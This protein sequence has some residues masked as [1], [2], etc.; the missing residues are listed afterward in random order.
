MYGCIQILERLRKAEAEAAELRA[1]L[2]Q[3]PPADEMSDVKARLSKE[4]GEQGKGSAEIT[5]ANPL[6]RGGRQGNNMVGPSEAG[7]IDELGIKETENVGEVIRKRFTL[8]LGGSAV[9]ALLAFVPTQ[10]HQLPKE[11]ANVYIAPVIRSKILLDDIQDTIERGRWKQMLQL[12]RQILDRPNYLKKNVALAAQALPSDEDWKRADG[13]GRELVEN[14][15]ALDYQEFFQTEEPNAD[16]AA[17]LEQGVQQCLDKIEDF[18]NMMPR[19][20]YVKADEEAQRTR[21]AVARDTLTYT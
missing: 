18:L 21:S 10:T 11:P 2:A 7:L 12:V 20:E 6:R 19:S 8:A 17:F 9:L 16:Q 15:R 14:I 1:R 4:L 13:L 5:N 3:A